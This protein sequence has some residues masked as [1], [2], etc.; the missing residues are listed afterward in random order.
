M[1]AEDVMDYFT[2]NNTS[3]SKEICMSNSPKRE[4]ED[5]AA[6]DNATATMLVVSPAELARMISSVS[7]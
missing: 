1:C 5:Q 2:F 6:A 7:S 4:G 3:K